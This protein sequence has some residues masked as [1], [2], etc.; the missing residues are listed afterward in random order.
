[1]ISA[2]VG[3]PSSI[4][5]AWI[6]HLDGISPALVSTACPSSIGATLSLSS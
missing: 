2:E 5:A 4:V 3:P 1:M 6:T